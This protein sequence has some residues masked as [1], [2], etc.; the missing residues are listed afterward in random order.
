MNELSTTTIDLRGHPTPLRVGGDPAAPALLGL[1]G[2]ALSSG[3]SEL[4]HRLVDRLPHLD[5]SI[6]RKGPTS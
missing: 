3:W 1:H 2:E 5:R 6:Y 4:H